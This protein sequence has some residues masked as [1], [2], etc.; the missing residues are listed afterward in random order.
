M[1]RHPGPRLRARATLLSWA[2]A[3]GA[4][5]AC[6]PQ[7]DPSVGPG[8]FADDFERAQ[9]GDAWRRTG[10]NWSIRDGQ[11]RV[12][13]ARNRP[14]WLARRLPRDVRVEFDVRS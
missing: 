1:N 3:C 8:G 2:L 11:L 6:T 14:L 13:G 9:L 4:L 12:K 10:G 7:G 5:P